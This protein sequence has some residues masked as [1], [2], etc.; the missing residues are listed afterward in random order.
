MNPKMKTLWTKLSAIG[1]DP[2]SSIS[3]MRRVEKP[4]LYLPLYGLPLLSL[5]S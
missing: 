1:Q 5:L 4:V 2:E 3:P